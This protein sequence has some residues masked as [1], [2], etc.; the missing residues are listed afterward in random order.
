MGSGLFSVPIHTGG[1]EHTLEGTVK[2]KNPPA[3]ENWI[4]SSLE[5]LFL[6]R[7]APNTDGNKDPLPWT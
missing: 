3:L 6:H 2:C 1:E 4:S 7:Y 5:R